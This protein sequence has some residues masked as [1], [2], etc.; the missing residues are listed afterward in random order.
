MEVTRSNLSK[1][2]PN[3]TTIFRNAD[4]LSF[5]M[6]FTGLPQDFS[7]D[8]YS[9]LSQYLMLRDSIL[10]Y[11]PFRA[12]ICAFSITPESIKVYPYTFYLF[13]STSHPLDRSYSISND[14]KFAAK[15]GL[16]FNKLFKEGIG[17]KSRVDIIEKTNKNYKEISHDMRAFHALCRD[18]VL[19]WDD[20]DD[21][22]LLDAKYMR[23]HVIDYTIQE[24]EKEFGV[25]GEIKRENEIPVGILLRRGKREQKIVN[26]DGFSQV[27]DLML[28]KPLVGYN[29]YFDLLHLYDKFI[30][31]L[32]INFNEFAFN[33]Q[34]KFPDLLDTKSI[35]Q[36]SAAVNQYFGNARLSQGLHDCWDIL[37]KDKEYQSSLKFEIE[38]P[39]DGKVQHSAGFDAFI[40]G[41]ILLKSMKIMNLPLNK[42][43]EKSKNKFFFS[44]NK[45][46]V[47]LEKQ[48]KEEIFL[49][50]LESEI[51]QKELKEHLEKIYGTIFLLEAK[52][53]PL[54]YFVIPKTQKAKKQIENM[55]KHKTPSLQISK[56]EGKFSVY[57]KDQKIEKCQIELCLN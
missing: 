1:I 42:I 7:Y 26:I 8:K 56:T 34:E 17:F 54:T 14:M 15:S 29:M 21:E 11:F 13:P 55:L 36:T 51:E 37:Q 16:D 53:M 4:F 2:L 57:Q 5:D 41:S 52:E 49:L 46:C 20:E 33:L 28:G 38:P 50:K 43:F 9:N 40:S 12:G 31:P 27:I 45:K 19:L 22:I 24:L 47:D 25:T 39:F 32:P 23:F 10:K 18:K 30:N 44:V 48:K 35:I 6:E 3:L